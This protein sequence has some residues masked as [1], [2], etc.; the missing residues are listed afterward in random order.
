LLAGLTLADSGIAVC[1]VAVSGTAADKANLV[2]SLAAQILELL[3]MPQQRLQERVRVDGNFVGPGYGL[4]AD[5]MIEAVDLVAR[6]E[7]LLLDPVYTGKA[8]AGL[9][10]A[11][12]D[13]QFTPANNVLFW[14]TGGAVALFAYR[15]V[16]DRFVRRDE[17]HPRTR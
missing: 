8:M 7:G 5:G 3:D 12:R 16:F 2:G 9:I 4:P 15:D 11:I 6:L 13:G 1:G 10:H 17:K 14:H